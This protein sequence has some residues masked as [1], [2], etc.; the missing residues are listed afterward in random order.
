MYKI[1][2]SNEAPPVDLIRKPAFIGNRFLY[3]LLVLSRFYYLELL[4]TQLFDPDSTLNPEHRPKYIGLLAYACS[5][6]EANKK[7]DFIMFNFNQ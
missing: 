1:Y 7:V 4:I 6:A 5:V 3:I 2:Q